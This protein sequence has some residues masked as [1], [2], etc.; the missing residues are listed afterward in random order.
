MRC[1]MNKEDLK[2]STLKKAFPETLIRADRFGVYFCQWYQ[3]HEMHTLMFG[4]D[5]TQG[6][7]KL[8]VH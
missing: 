7:F 4:W 8:T 3:H 5:K 6:T 2:M 1:Q